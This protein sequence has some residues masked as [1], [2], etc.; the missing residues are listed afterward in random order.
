MTKPTAADDYETAT[1]QIVDAAP[2]L[3]RRAARQLAQLIEDPQP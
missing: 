3:D 1:E 2:P